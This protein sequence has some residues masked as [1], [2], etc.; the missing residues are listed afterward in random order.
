MKKTIEKYN[1]SYKSFI[2]IIAASALLVSCS[3]LN[4]DSKTAY[5]SDVIFSSLSRAEMAVEGIYP[6]FKETATYC[7]LTPD[8]DEC[9]STN[10]SGERYGLSKYDFSPSSA[11]MEPVFDNRYTAIN[12]ANECISGLEKAGVLTSGTAANIASFNVLYGESLALR[13]WAYFDLI[14][15]WGDVPFPLTPSTAGSNFNLPRVS[16]DTIYDKIIADLQTAESIVPWANEVSYH[17]RITKGAVK[18]LLARIALYA[19]GYSL[20]WDL[21]ADGSTGGNV[22][23]R[24][25]TDQSR[26]TALYTIAKN[27]CYDII[28]QEGTQYALVTGYENPFIDSHNKLYDK[29]DIWELGNYGTN[30]NSGVGYYIGTSIGSGTNY[31]LASGPQARAM[32]T[33]YYSFDSLDTRRDVACGNYSVEATTA[34]FNL[35]AANNFACGKWRRCWQTTQGPTNG[36]TDINWIML[37]YSDVLLMYSEAINELSTSPTN[38]AMEALKKV[39]R[40]AFPSTAYQTKVEDYVNAL[41]TQDVFRNAII[42]ERSFELGFEANLRRTDLIRWNRLASTI[43]DTRAK[44]TVLATGVN[45][46]TNATIPQYRFYIKKSYAGSVPVAVPFTTSTSSTPVPSGYTS[47]NF[48]YASIITSLNTNFAKAF[49]QNKSELLPLPQSIIDSDTALTRAQHPGY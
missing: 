43:A 9:T 11:Q 42:K 20:R 4:M 39:R 38:D 17:D 35:V 36:S 30:A 23:I 49:T 32:P 48:L 37:R 28:Q 1:C 45:P 2:L 25:R 21:N 33:Y 15:F 27:A 8:N 19:A 44:M 10:T 26:I 22:G 47:L 13:A 7:Y 14:R 29:E 24:R 5:E 34:N 16:R 12:S 6:N 31:Y 46:Y 18:G 40:R 3:K 41:A